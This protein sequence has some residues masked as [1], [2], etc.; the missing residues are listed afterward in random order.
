MDMN[1][2]KHAILTTIYDDIILELENYKREEKVQISD[3]LYNKFTDALKDSI[4]DCISHFPVMPIMEICE[5][6][7]INIQ[8]SDDLSLDVSGK[9]YHEEDKFF[10]C[11]NSKHP[12][13]RKIF[14]LAHILGHRIFHENKIKEKEFVDRGIMYNLNQEEETIEMQANVFAG[15]MLMPRIPF[16]NILQQSNDNNSIIHQLKERFRVSES[17]ICKRA[18]ILGYNIND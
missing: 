6:M 16:K 11:L 1:Y 18:I 8:D 9:I 14:T 15:I 4:N 17:A 12:N 3:E 2:S 7:N 13:L 5:R 10:I